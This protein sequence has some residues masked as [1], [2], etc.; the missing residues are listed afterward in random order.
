MI[1]VGA[2]KY[3]IISVYLPKRQCRKDVIMSEFWCSVASM[4][5]GYFMYL[6]VKAIF[7]K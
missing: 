6:G 5:L 1:H 3:D 7:K 4:V 2:A